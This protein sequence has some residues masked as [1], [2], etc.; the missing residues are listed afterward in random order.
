MYGLH[1]NTLF[2]HLMTRHQ[3]KQLVSKLSVES[4]FFFFH[5]KMPYHDILQGQTPECNGMVNLKYTS[6]KLKENISEMESANTRM[7]AAIYQQRY[8][9]THSLI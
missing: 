1:V 7:H 2:D 4:F 5:L 3:L 6:Y 8:V 9:Y